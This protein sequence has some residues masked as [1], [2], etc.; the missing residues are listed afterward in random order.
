ML[1]KV[2]PDSQLATPPVALS[3][4]CM[5]PRMIWR[6]WREMK[7]GEDACKTTVVICGSCKGPFD[8]SRPEEYDADLPWHLVRAA[9]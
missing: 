1:E 9:A 6:H 8:G 5:A 2:I 7:A 3:A 4:C